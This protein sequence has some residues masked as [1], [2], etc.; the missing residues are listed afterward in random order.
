[1]NRRGFLKSILAA[2]VAPYVVTTA[3]VLMPVRQIAR[4]EDFSGP[5]GVLYPYTEPIDAK[6]FFGQGIV[7]SADHVE[8]Q[9]LQNIIFKRLLNQGVSMHP[10]PR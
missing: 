2:G 4:L 6:Q 9:R 8:A 3:G 1:M 10:Y 7:A 5:W